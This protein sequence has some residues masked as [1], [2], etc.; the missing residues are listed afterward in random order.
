MD[1]QDNEY[2]DTMRAGWTYDL[3]NVEWDGGL[4][5]TRFDSVNGEEGCKVGSAFLVIVDEVEWTNLTHFNM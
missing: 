5:M 2:G 3:L 4:L 1:F